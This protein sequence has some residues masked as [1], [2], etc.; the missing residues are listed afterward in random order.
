M[1]ARNFTAQID[2]QVRVLEFFDD[3][4]CDIA[5]CRHVTLELPKS[6]N[7]E[8]LFEQLGMIIEAGNEI[9]PA[10]DGYAEET[11]FGVPCGNDIDMIGYMNVVVCRCCNDV[12]LEGRSEFFSLFNFGIDFGG[13]ELRRRP[14]PLSLALDAGIRAILLAVYIDAILPLARPPVTHE[15]CVVPDTREEVGA[16]LFEFVPAWRRKK[17][18]IVCVRHAPLGLGRLGG[19]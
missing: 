14:I 3:T 15:L 10:K 13:G 1:L 11:V 16:N 5:G 9:A 6:V 4:C 17:L 8:V 19:D 12:G 2:D 18:F 7:T